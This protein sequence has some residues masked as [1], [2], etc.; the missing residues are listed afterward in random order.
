MAFPT[1][2]AGEI[3]EMITQLP[4]ARAGWIIALTAT[5]TAAAL[6]AGC[7]G[8]ASSGSE[9]SNS[10]SS[11]AGTANGSAA[12]VTAGQNKVIIDGQDQGV[13][14]RINCNTN[15]GV[16]AKLGY[17][18]HGAGFELNDA[19]PPEVKS[20]HFDRFVVNGTTLELL[21]GADTAGS[22][23]AKA[24]KDGNTYTVTGTATG[25]DVSD[26]TQQVSKSFEIDV[27]CP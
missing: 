3:H 8:N 5:A 22:G 2:E 19:D 21:F 9:S 6:I 24:A 1:L 11:Q 25:K 16:F 14:E 27:T 18:D 26:P 13:P 10:P 15:G 12:T 4:P 23:N 20:V 17:G 7:G